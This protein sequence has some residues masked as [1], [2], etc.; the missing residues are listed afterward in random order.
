MSNLD[1][2]LDENLDSEGLFSFD[3]KTNA[4]VNKKIADSF[5]EASE[6]IKSLEDCFKSIALTR[7]QTGS[8]VGD[9]EESKTIFLDSP[10]KFIIVTRYGCFTS[11]RDYVSNVGC[12]AAIGFP[13]SYL[14]ISD[15]GMSFTVSNSGTYDNVGC[16][17]GGHIYHF[18]AFG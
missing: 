15:D 2:F 16:N 18:F 4:Q 14:A 12:V 7:F 10:V 5:R 6:D 11:G 3:G 1:V 13:A 9:N 8:Y 17:V